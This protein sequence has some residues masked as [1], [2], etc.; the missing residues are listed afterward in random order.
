MKKDFNRMVSH[1]DSVEIILE[2]QLE[3]F[4]ENVVK[5]GFFEIEKQMRR[6]E[7]RL[8]NLGMRVQ[9]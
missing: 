1:L 5:K 3:G 4:M 7:A 9:D 8:R 6:I 2:D